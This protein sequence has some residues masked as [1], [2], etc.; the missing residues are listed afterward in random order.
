MLTPIQTVLNHLNPGP[1]WISSA[2]P[3]FGR[4]LTVNSEQGGSTAANRHVAL[5]PFFRVLVHLL[6]PR[7]STALKSPALYRIC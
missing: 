5:Y 7:G 2:L 3:Y 6:E 1:R 4:S